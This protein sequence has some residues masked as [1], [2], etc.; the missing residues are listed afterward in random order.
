MCASSVAL[1]ATA[2]AFQSWR[3]DLMRQ[4]EL[5]PRTL[6]PWYKR[7][8]VQSPLESLL[9]LLIWSWDQGEHAFVLLTRFW[10]VIKRRLW[11]F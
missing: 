4:R 6:L 1:W 5:T 9:D 11:G 2:A 10:G 3:T 8:I 7:V